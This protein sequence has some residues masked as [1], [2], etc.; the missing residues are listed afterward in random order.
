MSSTFVSGSF[1]YPTLIEDGFDRKLVLD[2]AAYNHINAEDGVTIN[3]DLE[4]QARFMEDNAQ[5]IRE[6]KT[7]PQKPLSATAYAT[8]LREFEKLMKAKRAKQASTSSGGSSGSLDHRMITTIKTN[9][10]KSQLEAWTSS[11]DNKIHPEMLKYLRENANH[12]EGIEIAA[13]SYTTVRSASLSHR[14]MMTYLISKAKGDVNLAVRWV[15]EKMVHLD[16]PAA[17]A[18]VIAIPKSKIELILCEHSMRQREGSFSTFLWEVYNS[19]C[20]YRSGMED[21]APD[22]IGGGSKLEIST[23]V[24]ITPE[25]KRSRRIAFAQANCNYLRSL[26]TSPAFIA[27]LEAT[28]DGA[29]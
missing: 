6:F 27:I 19:G 18:A 9:V 16:D 8:A 3:L 7:E 1:F 20:V 13:T 25:T 15:E 2:W 29:A 23:G 12:F 21:A 22:F 10:K 4:D 5:R 14:K 11:A 17:T 28:E 26:F 24:A